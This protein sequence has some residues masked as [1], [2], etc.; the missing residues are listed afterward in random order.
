MCVKDAPIIA[1]FNPKRGDIV[2]AQFILDNFWNRAMI[3][4]APRG[5]VEMIN[6]KACSALETFH[7]IKLPSL[8]DDFGPEEGKY[9]HAVTL[10]NGKYFNPLIEERD[11]YGGKVKG[12]CTGA[13]IAVTLMAVN[14]EISVNVAMLLLFSFCHGLRV[15]SICV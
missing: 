2:L 8:K 7:Y 15:P 1:S 12:Q 4:N 14:N 9:L 10:G 3:V 13:E 11:T 5:A 6:L